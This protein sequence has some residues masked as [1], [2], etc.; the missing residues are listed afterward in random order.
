MRTMDELLRKHGQVEIEWR[1]KPDPSEPGLDTH[2]HHYTF[3]S[4]G[5]AKE[6]MEQKS[7]SSTF[8]E[9]RIREDA[10]A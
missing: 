1:N 6:F 8:F 3:V 4:K 7:K 2:W 10:G 9:Y 5:E